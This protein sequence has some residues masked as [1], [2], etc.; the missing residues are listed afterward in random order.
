[1]EIYLIGG[2]ILGFFSIFLV[3]SNLLGKIG[4]PDSRFAKELLYADMEKRGHKLHKFLSPLILIAAKLAGPNRGKMERKLVNAGTSLGPSE[5]IALKILSVCIFGLF[6]FIILPLFIRSN[7][8]IFS[9]ISLALGILIP[10]IWLRQKIKKRHFNIA[11]DLPG[12]IDLL[13]LCVGAGLDFMLAARKVIENF[14][15]CE[16]VDEL[17][18]MIKEIDVGTSRYE[19]LKNLSWRINL[20]EISSFSRTLIQT[21]RFGAPVGEA[22]QILSDEINTRRFQ[23][24]EEMALKA[25]IKLLFPLVIFIL[26]VV[27]SIVAGPII[28]TFLKRG[29]L[30]PF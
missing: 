4:G 25:P 5:F 18:E 14:K 10:D 16:L 6:A 1:M 27:L 8:L 7:L 12:A 15:R 29:S 9:L 21:D 13:N 22:L 24:G 30:M 2:L 28:L 19:A 20:P 17:K 26:P 23:K 3:I 11:R